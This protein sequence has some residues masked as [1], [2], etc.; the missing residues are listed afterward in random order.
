MSLVQ[1]TGDQIVEFLVAQN[2]DTVFCITGAGNLAIVDAFSRYPQIRL[3]FSHHEQACVMEAVGYSK[4]SGKPGVA[5]VTTGAGTSNALTGIVS[6]Q[7]DS[8]PVLVISGNESSFHC[9]SMKN[10]R[11][12]G[13]QGFDSV[14]VMSPVT[15]LST[16]VTSPES[17][18][19]DM[20]RAWQ[21][22]ISDRKGAVHV[23]IPMDIQRHAASP[24]PKPILVPQVVPKKASAPSLNELIQDLQKAE[25]PMLYV[26]NGLRAPGAKAL[27]SRFWD[28]FR[29]PMVLSWSGLDLLPEIHEGNFGR[30]GIYGDRFS[31]IS[32]QKADF[33]LCL[34][35]RLAIPQVGYDRNDFARNAVKWVVDIDPIE[36]TKNTGDKWKGIHSDA[37]ELL[38]E[39]EKQL[40]SGKVLPNKP[41]WLAELEN[42]KRQLPRYKQFGSSVENVKGYIHSLEVIS[43]LNA[44]LK[45]DSIVVTDVGAGLLSGHYGLEA[46]A[47]QSIFTSQGLGEMGFGLPGAIGAHFAAPER[48]L[49]C[50]NTDGAVMF[51]LQELEVV[52]YF[53]IPLK[54]F[55]FNNSGY[56]MIKV[57]QDNLFDGRLSGINSST[58]ISFPNF[59]SLAETFGLNYTKLSNSND[60]NHPIARALD[61]DDSELIE[62]VMDPDQKYLPRLSTTKLSDG[63]LASPPIEDLDP[64]IEISLLEGLLGY[65]ASPESY[66]S[67]GLQFDKS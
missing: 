22:M 54:L 57:S 47:E 19:H 14:A 49:I 3:V 9:E 20:S 16:R 56:G 11:A 2:V 15:K 1:T 7:M 5:L 32:I 63:S 65:G 51:N 64:K 45:E 23:D 37:Y 24:A 21:S 60:L 38:V 41:G 44:I 17:A 28:K 6:A 34:G 61:S 50:L 33:L 62:V 39:L 29:I 12:F 42:L 53:S 31:N 66:K 30:V 55:I 43:S 52:R 40:N 46:K 58:G 27:L 18:L 13:V 59:E 4:T 26:G 35:T 10:F 36:L 8:V 25:R 67:R 48:Q